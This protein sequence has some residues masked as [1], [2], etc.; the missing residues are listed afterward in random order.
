MLCPRGDTLHTHTSSV[1]RLT[2]GVT[3]ETSE[4]V[5]PGAR[6]VEGRAELSVDELL[7]SC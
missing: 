2:R 3:P 7:P 1:G 6:I 5:E 4:S